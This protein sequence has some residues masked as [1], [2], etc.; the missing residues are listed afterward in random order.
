M[1]G[2]THSS[3]K[4]R[5]E[6]EEPTTPTK[7]RRTITDEDVDADE[8][9]DLPIAT[10]RSRRP[11]SAKQNTT[12]GSARRTM[13][14]RT[15]KQELS[16]GPNSDISDELGLREQEDRRHSRNAAAVASGK[17]IRTPSA[18]LRA[19]EAT[20]VT[21]KRRLPLTAKSLDR[22]KDKP[23]ARESKSATPVKG[24]N[25]GVDDLATSNGV[26][27]QSSITKPQPSS[28]RKTPRTW[29]KAESLVNGINGSE[30]YLA[31]SPYSPGLRR[32]PKSTLSTETVTTKLLPK[33]QRVKDGLLA[34]KGISF[35]VPALIH[36][37]VGK[38]TQRNTSKLIGLEDSYGKVYQLL[39]QTVSA[40][41][42][43]TLMITG[44]RGSG[45]SAIVHESIKS[46]QKDHGDSFFVVHLDG[47]IHTDDKIALRE[48]WKQLGREMSIE[49]DDVGKSYSDILAKLLALLESQGA[50]QDA[51]E[52]SKSVIFVIDEFELFASHGRQ[53]LLYNLFDIAQA[54]KAPIAVLGLT[55]RI[56]VVESLEKRVKSRFS[57]RYV[58]V[59]PATSFTQFKD[60]CKSGL[61]LHQ[62]EML[63]QAKAGISE[64]EQG[65]VSLSEWNAIVTEL[66]EDE[67]FLSSYV[68]PTFYRTK[69]VQEVWSGLL[70][71]IT[72][73]QD[74]SSTTA[75]QEHLLL[76]SA[77]VLSF[78]DS[79]LGALRQ[80]S[81]LQLALLICA[82]RLDII[83]D[84]DTCNF[85]MAYDEY[86]SL[87]AKARIQSSSSGAIATG[88]G[89][90]VWSR[91][92]ARGEW[93]KLIDRALLIPAS[94][95]PIGGE[96]GTTCM[97][98][99]DAS[100]EEI[101]GSAHGLDKTL[102]KW[103]KQI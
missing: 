82:A 44:P 33:L 46:L 11:S 50:S 28:L 51:G 22:V 101:A 90:R 18:K 21:P 96:L 32:V 58:H 64:T 6:E 8:L 97:V 57:H 30:N 88:A 47:F 74:L 43:N 37:V 24:D 79:K 71:P 4:R 20:Q 91:D 69:K 84:T 40:G 7:S 13:S 54:R 86:V 62:A 72:T 102:E 27:L 92:V 100:L 68:Y 16:C 87:A 67:S 76:H 66:F 35:N 61:L 60:R 56:N 98:R 15:S 29:Q 45:K 94:A 39:E 48:I 89:A 10:P 52:V 12:N 81:E 75:V 103:C 99:V 38:V 65:A 41:E 80:L 36:A 31:V 9:G 53:T 49:D 59:F 42:S 63:F 1:N 2:T 83:L 23:T 95:V 19:S 77:D 85:N 55:T 17:R 14:Q 26:H 34:T 70:L 5:F 93:E 78:P 3:K 73:L 25:V